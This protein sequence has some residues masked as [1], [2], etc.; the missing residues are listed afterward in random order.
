MRLRPGVEGAGDLLA[1]GVGAGV[2]G[3]VEVSS[4]MDGRGK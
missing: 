4:S 1:V 2:A 3:K